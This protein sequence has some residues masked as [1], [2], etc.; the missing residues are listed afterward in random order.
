[1]YMFGKALGQSQSPF[2]EE[3]GVTDGVGDGVLL[4]V[5]DGVDDGGGGVLEPQRLIL[6]P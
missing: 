2:G 4:G 1:M 5:L 3:D 6:V